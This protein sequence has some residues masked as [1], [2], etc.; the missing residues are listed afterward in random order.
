VGESPQ[1]SSPLARPAG[2]VS[3]RQR[4]LLTLTLA[5]CPTLLIAGVQAYV[6][7]AEAAEARQRELVA[8]SASAFGELEQALASAEALLRVFSPEIVGGDCKGVFERI[9]AELPYVTGVAGFDAEGR[10]LCTSQGVAPA[11]FFNPHWQRRLDQEERV[12]HT[13]AYRASDGAGWRFAVLSPLRDDAGEIQGSSGVSIAVD[14]LTGPLASAGL[15]E[16]SE[17]ALADAAG[18]VFQSERFDAVPEELSVEQASSTSRLAQA[19]GKD[20]RAYEVVLQRLA[21]R[22]LFAVMSRPAPGVVSEAT[23][24]PLRSLGV[25]LLAVSITLLAAWL[26]IDQLVLKWLSRLQR[27]AAAYGAGHYKFRDVRTVEDSPREI[28]DLAFALNL[29]A[30][31]IS[32]RDASLRTALRAQEDAMREIHHRVKNN[33]QIVTSFLSLQARQLKDPEARHALAAARH[34]IDALSI[35][36][37]TLYQHD[38][39]DTVHLKPF[40]EGLLEHLS[41]ALGMD[42]GRVSLS[43]RIDSADAPSDNAIPMALFLVEAVT[44][45]VRYGFPDRSGRISVSLGSQ[46]EALRLEVADNGRGVDLSQPPA[47]GPGQGLG[48]RLMAAFAKQLRAEMAITSK[49]EEGYAVTLT[50]PRPRDEATPA[51]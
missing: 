51:T 46:P 4:L 39:L 27:R 24:E 17:I 15:P 42:D 49:P 31:R 40:L 21:D 2:K 44:N 3:L 10:S 37:Q 12:L 1:P 7:A 5:L 48:T 34:R 30:D 41:G 6:D 36:H 33:L 11:R 18:R 47:A 23:L 43:W 9:Q 38:Q 35:V 22:P 19:T 13:E 29:M 50:I 26:A 8:R 20:G 16:G 28:A 45:A 32:E 14:G 25:P